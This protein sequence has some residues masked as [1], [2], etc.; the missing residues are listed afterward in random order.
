MILFVFLLGIVAGS[1]LSVITYR[2]PRQIGFV[3]D[4]S[5]CPKCGKEILWFDNIPLLSYFLLKGK[6]RECKT[7][8]PL[9]YLALE[10]VTGVL[11]VLGYLRW[12]NIGLF[13]GLGIIALGII[14]ILVSLV[15]AVAVVDMEYQIIPDSFVYTLLGISFLAVLPNTG[16]YFYVFAGLAASMFLL[17]LHYITK[18]KGMGLGDVKL[19]LPL[20]MVLGFPGIITWLFLSFTTGAVVGVTMLMLGRAEFG[21]HIPFGPFLVFSFLAVLFWGNF[22]TAL[23]L[24]I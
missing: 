8:I 11:F 5:R 4:R 13:S 2:V 15:V 19:A 24:P 12:E 6:C 1:F 20:G 16:F 10:A 17:F 7:T 9:R 22:L 23:I 14:F 21:R 18:G 3:T